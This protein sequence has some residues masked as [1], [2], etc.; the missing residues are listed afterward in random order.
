MARAVVLK[1]SEGVKL[2]GSYQCSNGK[3]WDAEGC[4]W[5][6]NIGTSERSNALQAQKLVSN[7]TFLGFE[8]KM[9]E[10]WYKNREN[11]VD[12]EIDYQDVVQEYQ[13]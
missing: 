2:I 9:G 12:I 3:Y 11:F 6:C 7:A 4:Y 10:D 8:P 5:Y 1:T 13:K